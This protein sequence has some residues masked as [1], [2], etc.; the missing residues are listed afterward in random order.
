MMESGFEATLSAARVARYLEW[1]E[2]DRVRA[3]ELYALNTRLSEAL[4]TSL[5]VLEVT[6]RNRIHAVMTDAINDSWFS[7]EGVLVLEHQLRQLRKARRNLSEPT[8]NRIV[9]ALSLSFW[10]SLL[11]PAYEELWQ[12][13]LHRIARR[14]DGRGL[15]RQDLAQPLAEI[16]NLRNRVAHHEA[17]I[18]WDIQQHYSNIEQVICWLSPAA[19]NWC[20]R[21]S[22]LPE[23]YPDGGI[24]LAR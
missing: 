4:Y 1:A 6:L 21:H 9:A 19:R 17:I 16:R 3:L 20:E 15:R 24:V 14:N 18:H 13:T 8:P 11:S 2:G 22:R 12:T 23:V 7:A 5:Q 10:V